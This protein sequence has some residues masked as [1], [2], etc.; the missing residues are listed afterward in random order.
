M[1]K[2][3]NKIKRIN[4]RN[5]L[6]FIKGQEDVQQDLYYYETKVPKGL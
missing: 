1:H 6:V 3:R 4:R 2:K 5:F